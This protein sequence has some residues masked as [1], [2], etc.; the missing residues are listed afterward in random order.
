MKRNNRSCLFSAAA[1]FILMASQVRAEDLGLL[2]SQAL[3]RYHEGRYEE[4]AQLYRKIIALRPGDVEMLRNLMWVLWKDERFN[5][6]KR[7]ATQLLAIDKNDAEAT[8]IVRKAPTLALRAEANANFHAGRFTQANKLYKDLAALEPDNPSVLRDYMWSLWETGNYD[9]A[10]DTAKKILTLNKSDQEA[11]DMLTKAPLA[12]LRARAIQSYKAKRYQDAIDAYQK[13][14]A[15]SPNS[16]S[17]LKDIYWCQWQL[18]HY[19]DVTD[20]ATNLT[21]LYPNDPEVWNLLGRAHVANDKLEEGLR[22]YNRSLELKPSQPDTQRVVGRLHVDLREFD[23][24]IGVLSELEAKDPSIRTIYPQLAK[25]QFFKG[26]YSESAKNWA[27]AAQLYPENDNY[28]LH[29][30]RALYYNGQIPEAM[31]KLEKLA[32]G[33]GPMKWMA[34]DFIV[35]DAL[36]HRDIK[37][38]IRMLETNLKGNVEPAQESRLLKLGTIYLDNHQ[39]RKALQT[40]NRFLKLNPGNIPGLLIKADTLYDLGH[41]GA[42]ARI[43]KQVQKLN[44]YSI[45]AQEGLANAEFAAGNFHNALT[46]FDKAYALDPTDPYLMILEAH[47]MNE[48]G[49]YKKGR[50]VLLRWLN[51]N[52][53]HQVVPV[54]LYHGLTPFNRDP[55]L[56]YP[57][58]VRVS[59]FED[60]IRA[61]KSAGYTP[62]TSEQL[63]AWYK[64]KGDLPKKPILLTFDDGRLDSFKYADPILQKYGFKATM[65]VPIANIEGH[66]PPSY[67]SWSQILQYQKSGRWEFQS[68]ADMGH[69]RIDIDAKG[70]QGLFLVNRQWLEKEN[71]LETVKEWEER[72]LNDHINAKK[73][74]A[75]MLG[76]TPVAYAYPEGTYG[77]IDIVNSPEA[78]PVNIAAMKKE[79]QLAFHQDRFGLNVRT[80]DPMYLTR[81]EPNPAWTGEELVRYLQD[82]S[83]YVVIP[84]QLLWLALWNEKPRQADGYLKDLRNAGASQVVLLGEEGRIRS[85]LGDVPGARQSINAARAHGADADNDKLFAS[86]DVQGGRL[87]SPAYTFTEDNRR[88]RNS[89]FEQ[90]LRPFKVSK[91]NVG[92]DYMYGSY[93]EVGVSTITQ[94]GAGLSFYTNPSLFHTLSGR[95]MW[96]W[97]PKSFGVTDTY[98]ASLALDSRWSDSFETE[99]TGGRALYDTA[100][101]IQHNVTEDYGNLYLAFKPELWRISLKASGGNLSDDNQ[102]YG[103]QAG[104]SRDIAFGFRGVY[105]YT[106]D[107]M[108]E[109]SPLYYSPQ[110]LHQHQ[111][112]LQFKPA[113][114]V[115]EPSLTYMP[116]IGKERNTNQTFVQDIEAA[117]LFHIGRRTTLMP[118][119]GLT[120]TPTYTRD[121]YNVQLTIHF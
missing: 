55:M 19:K 117:V 52:K 72:V 85:A 80:R 45:N 39:S 8:T 4:A 9:E 120:K 69:G 46:A 5:D 58:H 89:I 31:T 32:N 61:L 30:A 13:L 86:I 51:E 53:N 22:A 65:F 84:R 66:M 49:L 78:V 24:A 102:R 70:R 107:N 29:E 44:P 104:I 118:F 113:F 25:A 110:Q 64:K 48:S 7:I 28:K 6:A 35:D 106:Y 2:R 101:A 76:K 20:I 36:S 105:R 62:I 60:H 67:V 95:A 17:I 79:Y 23:N 91:F 41:N 38:A 10:R 54:L 94:N 103:G 75:Q 68:H 21:E 93:R 119:Y 82:K 111:L 34:I 3:A 1:L 90:T 12:S 87:W 57:V 96:H 97:F 26:F 99:V 14:L 15:H 100:S 59:V 83:P 47:Y 116:G 71:R 63:A 92:I 18:G 27:K 43:Y 108:K 40:L 74:I 115:I 16:A 98:T 11:K 114:R 37:T 112:G 88:R 77:Q 50:N 81:L 73:K 121:T 56:A 33:N 109:I 42:A